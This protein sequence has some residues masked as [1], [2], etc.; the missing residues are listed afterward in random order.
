MKFLLIFIAFSLGAVLVTQAGI[1]NQL[2]RALEG[3]AQASIVSFTVGLAS[4]LILAL[5]NGEG[6]PR[7]AV[8]AQP[9][10]PLYLGGLLGAF[11][12]IMVV[13]LVPEMGT[14]KLF[15]LIVAGQM[16]ATLVVDQYG[17]LGLPKTPITWE[18]FSGA[19]LL[20]GGVYLVLKR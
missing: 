1:N 15:A 3:P 20:I 16:A 7:P 18:R 10:W 2:R 9:A 5:I 8:L 14:Q 13:I 12:V 19:C 11:Y 17:L 6:I 4:L